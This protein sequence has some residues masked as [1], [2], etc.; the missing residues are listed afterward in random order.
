M[1]I[2]WGKIAEAIGIPE[3]TFHNLRHR[4][5]SQLIGAK[6]DIVTIS[7]RLRHADPTIILRVSI[8]EFEE[9]DEAAANAINAALGASSV[10]KSG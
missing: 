10:P 6:V 8:H 4:H 9:S 5:A 2:R 7:A 3:V 1:S